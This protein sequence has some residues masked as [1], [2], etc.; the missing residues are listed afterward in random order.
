M[1]IVY[2]ILAHNNSQ[3]IEKLINKLDSE[4]NSFVI[5]FD[6]NGSDYDYENLEVIFGKK[7]NVFFSK[8]NRCYWGDI[9]LVDASVECLKTVYY[10]KINFD[11]AVLI[12]GQHYPIKKN[13]EIEKYLKAANNKS[14]ISYFKIPAKEWANE[15]GGKNRI[16]YYHFNRHP[17]KRFAIKRVMYKGASRILRRLGVKR[18]PPFNINNFYGGSQWWCLTNE[19]CTYI[20]NFIKEKQH[21]YKYFKYVLIPD[22]IFF[23]TILLNSELKD[24]IINDNL[25]YINWGKV[26]TPSPL[27]LDETHY[28]ELKKNNGLWAR[29][30]D[31]ITSEKL[32]KILDSDT[33]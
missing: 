20:L 25:T 27:T 31:M 29:K 18:K 26:P 12:S 17:R 7:K 10:N 3:Q 15:N 4:N 33:N 32:I 21:I 24:K 22:E 19:C 16:I 1:R 28:E 13:E 8:R 30:L 5:H 11:Y 6:L 23:Q 9:S 2:L 14:F